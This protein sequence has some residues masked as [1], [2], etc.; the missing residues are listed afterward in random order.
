M[1]VIRI[2]NSLHLS[3]GKSELSGEPAAPFANKMIS[4]TFPCGRHGDDV[5]F[6]P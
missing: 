1:V 5:L 3:R 4:I 6:A 2:K